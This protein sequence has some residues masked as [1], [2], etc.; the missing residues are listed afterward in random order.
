[1]LRNQNHKGITFVE[2]FI[3]LFMI[4]VLVGGC[5]QG[6]LFFME[7]RCSKNMN[8]Y[9]TAIE[10]FITESREKLTS[11]DDLKDFVKVEGGVRPHCGICPE[12]APYL[13]E[14]DERKVR[15]PYHGV[16]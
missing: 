14:P 2:V 5:W 13:L 12:E 6:Y 8:M 11:I 4:A 10:Q 9:N 1:M 15:C 7:W 3:Y 16:M